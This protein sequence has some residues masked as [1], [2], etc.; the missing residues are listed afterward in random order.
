[1][2][3]GSG[4]PRR[5][6]SPMQ[7]HVCRDHPR[8]G[9]REQIGGRKHEIDLLDRPAS[10]GCW[11]RRPGVGEARLP[12]EADA[13][14]D[15]VRLPAA[16]PGAGAGHDRRRRRRLGA[17]LD[18]PRAADIKQPTRELPE[19]PRSAC[20]RRHEASVN[21]LGATRSAYLARASFSRGRADSE[22]ALKACGVTAA[23]ALTG[24]RALASTLAIEP[25]PTRS[26]QP[27]DPPRPA[28]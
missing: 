26:R 12:A 2:S 3:G 5:S 10:R 20:L 6:A 28:A 21:A 13:I 22:A 27:P 9:D 14:A 17:G 4:T 19:L 8:R 16:G 1:M 23:G 18:A 15:G 24:A 7:R 11:R 25:R